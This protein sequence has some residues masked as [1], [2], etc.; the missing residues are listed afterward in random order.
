MAP[1]IEQARQSPAGSAARVAGWSALGVAAGYFVVMIAYAVAGAPPAGAAAR[2]AAVAEHRGAWAVIVG[3][4]V[5]TDLLLVPVAY[6]LYDLLRAEHPG[7]A[8]TGSGLL[9]LF[10]LLDLAV[11]EPG[12]GTLVGLA[13]AAS[14]G[15]GSVAALAAEPVVATLTSGVTTV[16]AILVPAVGI[17]L[18]GLALLRSARLGRRAG[19][20]AGRLALAIGITGTLAVVGPLVVPALGSLVVATSVFTTLWLVAV[21]VPLVRAG[22]P[23][24]EGQPAR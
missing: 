12:L 15:A 1:E 2:L 21:G 18:L 11:V 24:P 8:A 16:Y 4:S 19:P 9:G 14:T 6:G 20:L 10:A 23:R 17:L 3:A 7:L 22:A 5:A 13:A